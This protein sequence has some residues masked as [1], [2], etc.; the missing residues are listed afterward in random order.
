MV[1]PEERNMERRK[2]RDLLKE[3]QVWAPCVWDCV[4]A[5]AAEIAGYKAIILASS[6]YSWA[7]AGLPDLSMLSLDDWK[8]TIENITYSSPLPLIIDFED[9][10]GQTPS[11]VYRAARM[12]ARAGAQGLILY[13]TSAFRGT[14]RGFVMDES[15]ISGWYTKVIPLEDYL[16]KVKAAV[17]ACE[18]TDCIIIAATAALAS[19]YSPYTLDEAIERSVLAREMGAEMTFTAIPHWQEGGNLEKCKKIN[20]KLPGWKMY[21]DLCTGDKVSLDELKELGFNFVGTHCLHIGAYYGMLDVAIHNMQNRNTIYSESYGPEREKFRKEMKQMM[22]YRG[23]E[24]LA[25]EKEF[26]DVPKERKYGKEPEDKSCI[27]T[28]KMR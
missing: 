5:K 2:L 4:S 18:G 27:Y 11:H 1:L 23:Q 14:E 25:M 3:G 17:A 20:E 10:F 9:G 28:L 26:L 12:L 13:D 21:G 19:P 7:R 24:F 22:D 16:A 8:E 15:H 6:I